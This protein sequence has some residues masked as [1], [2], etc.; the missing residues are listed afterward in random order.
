MTD[1]RN[2]AD[3]ILGEEWMQPGHVLLLK[4]LEA[5]PE[6]EFIE[7]LKRETDEHG[8]RLWSLCRLDE[9]N[10][11]DSWVEVWL[12]PSPRDRSE[13]RPPIKVG[14]WPLR[15]ETDALADARAVIDEHDDTPR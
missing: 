3:R 15:L 1:D 12:L 7:E 11:D 4:A 14:T 5:H 2:E 10:V 8:E 9:E 6:R 13:D